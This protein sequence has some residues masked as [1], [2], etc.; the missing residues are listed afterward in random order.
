MNLSNKI[1]RVQKSISYK[2]D[3][4]QSFNDYRSTSL[5][6]IKNIIPIIK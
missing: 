4:E 1:I 5:F 3:L 6:V 2:D